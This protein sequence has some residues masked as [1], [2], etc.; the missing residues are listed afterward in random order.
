MLNR[1]YDM[2]AMK[3]GESIDELFERFNIVIVGLDAMGIKK[4]VKFKE[5]GK[6][7]SSRKQKKDFSKV[8]CYNCKETGHFKSD[9]PKLKKEEKPKK[10]KK[11]GLM[12]SWEDLENDSDDDEE[13][14]T[15]SQ[16]CLMADHIEQQITILK[17]ENGFL[18]DKLKETK[19]DVELVKEN[20]Q[21][22]AQLRGCES[23]H[24]IVS[25]LDEYDG[26]FV[27]FG[28]DG[29]GKI[30][31]I[32]KIGKSFSSSINDVLL[33]DGLKHNLLSV[34]Q[35][36][37]LGFEVIF[38]KFVCLVVCEKSGDI[39]F[40]A[41][42]TIIRKGL[43]KTPY[44]LWKGTPPNLKYF[45]VFRCKCFVLNN[46]ENLGKFDPKSYEGVFVG[47][48][49]TSKAYRIYLKEHRTIEESIHVSFCDSNSIPSTV[50]ENDSDCE[51][52]VNKE[53]N[54]ENPKSV[55]NEESVCPILSHQNGGDCFVL[56]P[57]PA[58][59]TGT[60]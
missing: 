45:H 46:K 14:E 13:S 19:T 39:L 50:I 30:V 55:Q 21:L 60:E 16:P 57:E 41:K 43:K 52:V 35:L 37:D 40:E 44:E 3:E 32:G 5:R 25:Y 56:S 36:C 4:M 10:G 22:K 33:V 54:E 2:F 49:T 29:K 11:K 42:R 18:R 53:T 51:D 59:E 27:T 8:T 24:S 20:M 9:C 31:A 12:A 7:S 15:M 17:A 1:E 28:N 38:R 48:S 6:G 34:S 47:Y 26:G 23:D 58:R